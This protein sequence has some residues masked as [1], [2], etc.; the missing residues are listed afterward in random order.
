MIFRR[1]HLYTWMIGWIEILSRP[2][3]HVKDF[4]RDSLWTYSS[5]YRKLWK[6][7]TEKVRTSRQ[8]DLSFLDRVVAVT[9]HMGNRI[10]LDP[11]VTMLFKNS[12]QW[13][14]EQY[15][16]HQTTHERRRRDLLI[17]WLLYTM[18]MSVCVFCGGIERIYSLCA[19]VFEVICVGE[20]VRPTVFFQSI[21]SPSL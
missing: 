3:C 15:V 11:Q 21:V 12:K 14:A 8:L 4:S 10:A 2:K 6:L 20:K 1:K 16:R 5:T 13:V 17:K 7:W 19:I 9:C 18:Y